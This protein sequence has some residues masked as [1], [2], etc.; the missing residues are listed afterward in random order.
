MKSTTVC[1]CDSS[2][3]RQYR[4]VLHEYVP[5]SAGGTESPALSAVLSGV[6]GDSDKAPFTASPFPPFCSA[7]SVIPERVSDPVRYEDCKIGTLDGHDIQWYKKI[8][9]EQVS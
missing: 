6:S 7:G 3:L 5:D 9:N 2:P 1:G 8:H 4:N